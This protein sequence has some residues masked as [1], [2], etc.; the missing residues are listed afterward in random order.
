MGES[1]EGLPEPW[2]PQS[3]KVKMNSELD[4]EK[5][6]LRK[7]TIRYM[8]F[9]DTHDALL[10]FGRFH[11]KRLS[12]MIKTLEGMSYMQWMEKQPFPSELLDVVE[13]RL[14]K[15]DALKEMIRSIP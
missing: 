13:Y 15:S 4:Q 2:Q 12:E 10:H 6:A 8:L 5:L 3:A 11:G 14:I 1:V 9:P 7:T